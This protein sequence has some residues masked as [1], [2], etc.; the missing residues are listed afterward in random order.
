M[1]LYSGGPTPAALAASGKGCL[2][3]LNPTRTL[4]APLLG[5]HKKM[6]DCYRRR[7][8]LVLQRAHLGPLR[9]DIGVAPARQEVVERTLVLSALQLAPV[10]DLNLDIGTQTCP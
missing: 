2:N 6:P 5:N 8:V 10:R 3:P 1:Y 7:P 4:T 9:I